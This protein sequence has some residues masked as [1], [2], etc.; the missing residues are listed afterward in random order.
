M[1]IIIRILFIIVVL[2][3]FVLLYFLF[4]KREKRENKIMILSCIIILLLSVL[5]CYFKI[6]LFDKKIVIKDLSLLFI[7]IFISIVLKY[8]HINRLSEEKCSRLLKTISEYEKIIDEQGEKNHEYNNQLMILKGYINN[9]E[10]LSEYLE[11]IISDHKTGQNFEIRQLSQFPNDGLK[12]ML[13]YK[14]GKIKDNNIKYYLYV[15]SEACKLLENLKINFYKD[16]T[17]VFGVLIDNAI[18]ASLKSEEKEVA[19]DFSDEEGQIIITISNTYNK[20]VDIKRIGKK[21]YST[22]GRGHG[23]GLKLVKDI[24]KRNKYL[25]LVTD[26]DEKYFNQTLIIYSK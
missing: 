1:H 9:K 7:A 16:I 10:K 8:V 11:S 25:E 26:N 22:K 17:K 20:N 19:I 3:L 14:I 18:D 6:D 2:E 21:G 15:S 13:Y 12:E 24:L 5:I 4:N 23:F